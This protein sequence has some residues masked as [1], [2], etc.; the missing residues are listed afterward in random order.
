MQDLKRHAHRRP[1]PR[2]HRS[3]SVSI[4]N[5]RGKTVILTQSNPG[6]R[7]AK[8]RRKPLLWFLSGDS[9]A[10]GIPPW[11]LWRLS[12]LL[13]TLSVPVFMLWLGGGM[14]HHGRTFFQTQLREVRISGNRLLQ[15]EEVLRI[16]G[17]R[18]G[19]SLEELDS[20]ATASMLQQHPVIDR[21][22]V[23]RIFP[24]RVHLMLLE[25]APA[26][27][28]EQ[29]TTNS[30]SPAGYWL[31]T[32]EKLVLK[33]VTEQEARAPLLRDQPR[34]RGLPDNGIKP[35][36]KWQSLALERGLRFLDTVRSGQQRT[37]ASAQGIQSASEEVPNGIQLTKGLVI[38][39]FDPLNLNIR[40][41]FPAAS[42]TTTQDPSSSEID[43]EHSVL[44]HIGHRNFA[45]RLRTLEKIVPEL[46]MSHPR[47]KSI[48]LRYPDRVTLVP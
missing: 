39:L 13:F 24:D 29:P 8:N 30:K 33:S 25:H 11:S 36:W 31:I 44:V 14:V 17:L 10:S 32:R 16:S 42:M 41:R 22:D 18:P 3:S 15:E 5:I 27:L 12:Q 45:E 2:K 7:P 28:I 21:A 37:V 43:K 20:F 46:L 40:M 19:M 35:G 1:A 47:M 48:D 23:R 4:R 6:K 38:N 34:I 9:S 26:A